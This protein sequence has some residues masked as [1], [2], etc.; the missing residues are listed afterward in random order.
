MT[1]PQCLRLECLRLAGAD[2]RIYVSVI[3]RKSVNLEVWPF[4]SPGLTIRGM[5]RDAAECLS[6]KLS[7]AVT[8]IDE[9][10]PPAQEPT[11]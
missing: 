7:A 5:T 1:N 11:P 8:I 3:D 10:Y 2:C 6:E 9:T 4:A